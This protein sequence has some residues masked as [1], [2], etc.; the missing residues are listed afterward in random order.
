MIAISICYRV[1][2]CIFNKETIYCKS[3]EPKIK[4]SF[5]LV[6]IKIKKGGKNGFQAKFPWR[7]CMEFTVQEFGGVFSTLSLFSTL[8][9]NI[10][11]PGKAFRRWLFS[12]NTLSWMFHRVLNTTLGII[13]ILEETRRVLNT[14]KR[15]NKTNSRIKFPPGIYL[16]KVNNRNT[17]TRCD[18]CLKLTI[19]IPERR[20][21][22]RSGVLF[23]NFEHISHLVLIFLLL[24]LSRQIPTGFKNIYLVLI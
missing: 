23:V 7:G 18:I 8:C 19:K 2:R 1:C 3:K 11:N 20:H 9:S 22:R 12:Q 10:S 6:M 24:I 4:D 14:R 15:W 17:R 5:R 16:L 21:W 13:D